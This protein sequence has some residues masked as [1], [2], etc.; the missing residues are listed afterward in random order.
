MVNLYYGTIGRPLCFT[1][2]GFLSPDGY[3]PLPPNFWWGGETSVSEHAQWLAEAAVLS[4]QSGKVRLMIIFNVDI[5]DYG[6]DPQGGYA[7]I[8]PGGSCPAC[9]TLDAVIP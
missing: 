9:D 1:E 3:G 7:I 6:A 4:S 2:L 5:F 8:R